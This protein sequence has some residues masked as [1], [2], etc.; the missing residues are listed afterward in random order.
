V[1]RPAD[2][3][4]LTALLTTGAFALAGCGATTERGAEAF[5]REHSA[6]AA[7]TAEAARALGSELAGLGPKPSASQLE[8]LAVDEHRTRR[9]LLAAAKW[10]VAENGEE[11]GV[12]QAEREINE[13]TGALLRAMAEV[14]LYARTRRPGD[15]AGYRLELASGREYWN[16]GVTE[17]WYVAHKPAPPKI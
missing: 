8:A 2:P 5:Y 15:I 10:T 12:S 6:E 16:Q 17:L 11:E 4:C 7:H 9:D 1:F 14:R 3:R 13:G